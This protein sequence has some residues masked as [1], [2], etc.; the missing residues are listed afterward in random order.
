MTIR[1]FISLCLLLLLPCY[2]YSQATLYV[3]VGPS[4]HPVAITACA[5]ELVT[6]LADNMESRWEVLDA[7]CSPKAV[8]ALTYLYMT[9][10]A[11]LLIEELYFDDGNA[12]A[13]F[14]FT[15]ASRYLFAFD[16]WVAQN[17]S[18]VSSPWT[19]TFSFGETGTS[20]VQQDLELGMN[21]HINY[22]L[23]IATYE[24]GY[25][26]VSMKPDYDRVNDLMAMIMFNLTADLGER[27]DSSLSPG[28]LNNVAFA[29][30]LD[31]IIEWR[32]NAWND[33]LTYALEPNGDARLLLQ[34]TYEGLAA[35]GGDSMETGSS[36]STTASRIA[37]C[38]AHHA[39]APF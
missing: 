39:P 3:D 1:F 6:S 13:S 37:Y 12:M 19:E 31:V 11:K 16:N 30:L 38:E 9:H 28:G 22:D 10:Y 21:A 23:A 20:T 17:Y 34:Q 36:S 24:S 15:F 8:F 33:A 27:Y 35:V 5:L 32:G 2:T 14:I 26:V 18:A 29:A 4:S 25:A 7:Q